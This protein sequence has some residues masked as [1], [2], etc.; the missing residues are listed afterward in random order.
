MMRPL[1]LVLCSLSASTRARLESFPTKSTKAT[2]L[3]N[4]GLVALFITSLQSIPSAPSRVQ[5]ANNSTSSAFVASY[6]TCVTWTLVRSDSAAAAPPHAMASPPGARESVRGRLFGLSSSG[7]A[8][9]R[10]S[11]AGPADMAHSSSP[12]GSASA[13]RGTFSASAA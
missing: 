13:T 3:N 10:G 6:A 12:K 5:G 8:P 2:P 9:T 11:P 4:G 7:P 1:N